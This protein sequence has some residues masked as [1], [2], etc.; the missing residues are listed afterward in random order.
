MYHQ[1]Y[2]DLPPG[3]VTEESQQ[4][5]TIRGRTSG[6]TEVLLALVVM[7]ISRL[8]CEKNAS[9]LALHGH[10]VVLTCFTLQATVVC[11]RSMSA[12]LLNPDIHTAM[13]DVSWYDAKTNIFMETNRL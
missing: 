7:D 4:K 5:S 6:V 10:L 2:D 13:D 3:Q 12:A 11:F 9:A 1:S 8:L